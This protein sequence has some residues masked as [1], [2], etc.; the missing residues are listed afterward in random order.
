[1]TSRKTRRRGSKKNDNKVE[2][3]AK[4]KLVVMLVSVALMIF[5][6]VQ[7]YYLL[8][9]TIGKD[10]PEEKLKV[11]RWIQLVVSGQESETEQSS[12]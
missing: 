3:K 9:Y 12:I 8:M 5:S 6:L 2:S 7:V 10:V 1:M 11:Y 4:V